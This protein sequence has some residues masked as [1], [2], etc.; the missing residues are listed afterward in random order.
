MRHDEG[1][2]RDAGRVPCCSSSS[3]AAQDQGQ[4]REFTVT[5]NRYAFSPS[6]ITVNRN[7]LVKIT[8]TAQDMPTASPSTAT[9]S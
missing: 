8:F 9:G 4:V 3:T 2:F 5:G 6:S 7:D 1:G